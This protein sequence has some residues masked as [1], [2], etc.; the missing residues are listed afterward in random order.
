MPFEIRLPEF[1]KNNRPHARY[2][3]IL[4][5]YRLGMFLKLLFFSS[6]S[7]FFYLLFCFLVTNQN[8]I[9]PCVTE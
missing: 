2:D 7:V 3:R 8:F 6:R 4:K 9:L 5:N 1:T